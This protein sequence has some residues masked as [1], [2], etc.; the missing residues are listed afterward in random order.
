MTAAA[1]RDFLWITFWLCAVGVPAATLLYAL[2]ISLMEFL[3]KE[4][5]E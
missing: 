1:V 3:S 4:G 2:V 5:D